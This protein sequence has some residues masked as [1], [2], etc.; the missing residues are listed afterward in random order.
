MIYDE[1][2][3]KSIRK[4]PNGRVVLIKQLMVKLALDIDARENP[5]QIAFI[6]MSPDIGE[7]HNTNNKSIYK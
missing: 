5:N 4:S 7:R 6:E 3:L 2:Y 1:R